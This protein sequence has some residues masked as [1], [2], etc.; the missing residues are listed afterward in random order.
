MA[1]RR[2]ALPPIERTVAFLLPRPSVHQCPCISRVSVSR[3]CHA[4][5][6]CDAFCEYGVAGSGVVSAGGG[7]RFGKATSGSVELPA[8][9]CS[10]SGRLASSSACSGKRGFALGKGLLVSFNIFAFLFNQCFVCGKT[11][12]VP[13]RLHLRLPC[14]VLC[15]PESVDKKQS[16]S[17]QSSASQPA[18]VFDGKEDGGAHTLLSNS[19]RSAAR[20]ATK[21]GSTLP[22]PRFHLANCS[23]AWGA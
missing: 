1:Q 23:A 18:P 20:R 12:S 3:L 4:P 21:P 2:A 17:Q 13:F 16:Q 19:A 22:P 14:F 8:Q 9:A 15:L 11:C 7:I 5:I 10:S 6:F